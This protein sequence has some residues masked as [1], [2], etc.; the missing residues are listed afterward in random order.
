RNSVSNAKIR[1]NRMKVRI[2]DRDMVGDDNISA[3]GDSLRAHKDTTDD[4]GIVAD[5]DEAARFHVERRPRIDP[6]SIAEAKPGLL[7]AAKT[8]KAVSTFDPAVLTDPNVCRQ[9]AVIPF[10]S[11]VSFVECHKQWCIRPD[12]YGA[13]FGR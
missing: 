7:C 1:I 8:G 10:A 5:F 9:A 12:R 2:G 3:D 6:H 13:T 11:D 4:C